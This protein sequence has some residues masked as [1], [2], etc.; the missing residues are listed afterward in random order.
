[1]VISSM[2]FNH[3]IWVIQDAG[4]FHIFEPFVQKRDPV[5]GYPKVFF[6]VVFQQITTFSCTLW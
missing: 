6:I 4:P 2:W 5:T 3:P 1:M